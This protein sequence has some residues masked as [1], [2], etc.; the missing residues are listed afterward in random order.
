MAV[1]ASVPTWRSGTKNA[2]QSLSRY[3]SSLVTA[4]E[5]NIYPLME[6]LFNLHRQPQSH[7]RD[8]LGGSPT[9]ALSHQRM[10]GN[11]VLF[12]ENE[13]AHPLRYRSAPLGP[14][15]WNRAYFR[16]CTRSVSRMVDP[17]FQ[18]GAQWR[19]SLG[20]RNLWGEGGKSVDI[21]VR[22]RDK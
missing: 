8:I 12:F 5:K 15:R 17:L 2:G 4:S 13:E 1:F 14:Q 20:G 10:C 7:R 6:Y 9:P 16:T 3:L 22:W 19:K 21:P 18:C 11:R